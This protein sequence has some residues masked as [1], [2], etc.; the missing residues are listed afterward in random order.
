[1]SIE[2]RLDKTNAYKE[3]GRV[4]NEQKEYDNYE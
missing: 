1:M 3:A 2:G 4:I